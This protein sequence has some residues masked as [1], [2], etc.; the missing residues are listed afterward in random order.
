MGQNQIEIRLEGTHGTFL[1]IAQDIKANGFNVS[2]SNASRK[3]T[4]AYFWERG[5]Y[6]EELAIGWV[7]YKASQQT[8]KTQKCAIIFVS[9]NLKTYEHID[10]CP[11]SGVGIEFAKFVK[12]NQEN[13]KKLGE[14]FDKNI[15]KLFNTFFQRF[16]EKSKQKI[17][18][19]SSLGVSPPSEYCSYPLQILG[20]PIVYTVRDVK[21]ISIDDIKEQKL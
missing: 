21:C 3:G 7:K 15:S 12:Q 13:A 17:K 19:V 9:L 8:L 18:V 10:L 16:E 20:S 1:H 4:G 5:P 2:L 6:A 11:N 14:K